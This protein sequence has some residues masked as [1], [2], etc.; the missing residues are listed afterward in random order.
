MFSIA[1]LER[2]KLITVCMVFEVGELKRTSL[3]VE[4]WEISFPLHQ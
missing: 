1:D 3:P 2:E 4:Q